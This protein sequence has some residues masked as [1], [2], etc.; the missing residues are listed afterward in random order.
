VDIDP[1]TAK[2]IVLVEGGVGVSD[3]LRALSTAA[4]SLAISG[5]YRHVPGGSADPNLSWARADG[6]LGWYMRDGHYYAPATL[7]Q[8]DLLLLPPSAVSVVAGALVVNADS[9]LLSAAATSGRLQSGAGAMWLAGGNAGGLSAPFAASVFM[10]SKNI[11]TGSVVDASGATIVPWETSNARSFGTP[12]QVAIIGG[13][14]PANADSV[15]ESVAKAT[16]G[17][18]NTTTADAAIEK[19]KLR[20]NG[21]PVV[22]YSDG[23]SAA[24][25]LLKL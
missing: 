18:L 7:P 4:G 10:D 23:V 22:R 6:V 3:L 24:S 13:S 11:S 21:L 17:K 20:L 25:A 8:P 2:A 19:L 1:A 5:G 9:T 15:V 16:A 12:S 14:G